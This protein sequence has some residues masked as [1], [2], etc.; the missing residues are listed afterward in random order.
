MVKEPRKRQAVARGRRNADEALLAALACGATVENAARTVGISARTAHRRLKEE[1]F[2]KRLQDVRAD[3]L[4][5]TVGMLTASGMEASKTLISLLDPSVPQAVR[6]GATR[7]I[8][9]FGIKLRDSAE[10]SERIATLE[11]QL[12]ATKPGSAKA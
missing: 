5:R 9:E 8:L 4:Q 6:L 1:G 2:Q 10:L 12:A 7:T 11:A 3:M